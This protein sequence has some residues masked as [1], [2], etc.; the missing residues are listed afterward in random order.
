MASTRPRPFT[1]RQREVWN[2]LQAMLRSEEGG[3]SSNAFFRQVRAV[4]PKVTDAQITAVVDKAEAFGFLTREA[5]PILGITRYRPAGAMAKAAAALA[6][7]EAPPVSILDVVE[8]FRRQ[9]LAGDT[10]TGLKMAHQWRSLRDTFEAEAD[11]L[12]RKMARAVAAGEEIRPSW[13]HTQGHLDALIRQ[14]DV[15][16]ARYAQSVRP[17]IAG[18]VESA[19][20]LAG[21]A[22][23][24]VLRAQGI[25]TTLNAAAVEHAAVTT[26][27]ASTVGQ[28][29]ASMGPQ[30]SEML[31]NE[32]MR[33]VAL[34]ESPL[35]V[36]ARMRRVADVPLA[37]AR[38]VART[39]AMRAYRGATAARL[40]ASGVIHQWIWIAGLDSRTCGACYALHGTIHPDSEV[41]ESHPNCRCVMAPLID[42]AGP[43]TVVDYTGEEAIQRMS[44]PDLVRQFGPGKAHALVNGEIEP[45][46][47]IGTRFSPAWGTTR[48]EASLRNAMANAQ[49]RGFVPP[50][51][52]AP[53]LTEPISLGRPRP[54]PTLDRMTNVRRPNTFTGRSDLSR[55]DV[56]PSSA[57]RPDY[58]LW[59]PD[60]VRPPASVRADVE[61]ALADLDD[62]VVLPETM[63]ELRWGYTRYPR[64]ANG[65]TVV[66]Q[67]Y[68]GA[69]RR[70]LGEVEVTPKADWG[71]L[72][73]EVTIQHEMGHA[74]DLTWGERLGTKGGMASDSRAGAWGRFHKATRNSKTIQR[75]MGTAYDDAGNKVR[76]AKT[77]RTYLTRNR[78]V[79][80][81]A[82]AQWMASQPGNEGRLYNL[83][84]TRADPT[85]RTFPDHWEADDFAPIAKAVEDVLREM[86]ALR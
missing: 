57:G 7:A 60:M 70:L 71:G 14:I 33:G 17:A 50:Q 23:D 59:P 4:M 54:A 45:R 56:S 44:T 46:D 85:V 84:V 32:L 38:T 63:P 55:L 52:T 8:R 51:M 69:P 66:T 27:H 25:G 24:A 47:L 16:V 41:M 81:R 10:K 31:R 39:E 74:L 73:M 2:V 22:H 1:P 53:T 82:F 18:N 19:A 83:I 68:P 43:H 64:T 28:V 15:E 67:A 42:G 6:R 86:G 12:A 30:V 21:N 9:M 78:E 29:L 36:A 72:D 37:R 13:L 62:H 75:I 79:W 20:A 49:R 35:Q 3:P 40:N 26:T 61:R 65:S 48:S 58:S 76:L 80:A 77:S 5:D 34:G 11:A